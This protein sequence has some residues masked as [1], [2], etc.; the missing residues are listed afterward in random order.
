MKSGDWRVFNGLL[1]HRSYEALSQYDLVTIAE[2]A[3]VDIDADEL[4]RVER[5]NGGFNT[6]LAVI[7]AT[8]HVD[9]TNAPVSME[10][11]IAAINVVTDDLWTIYR[12]ALLRQAA[13]TVSSANVSR[14]TTEN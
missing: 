8:A 3:A 2:Q 6:L 13:L 11:L 5:D 14:E 7:A 4:V 10:R 1:R 12:A 9:E